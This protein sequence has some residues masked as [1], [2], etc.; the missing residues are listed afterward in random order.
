MSIALMES[1]RK[2]ERDARGMGMSVALHATV[3]G[4]AWYATAGA[5]AAAVRPTAVVVI[6]TYRQPERPTTPSTARR[7]GGGPSQRVYDPHI[8]DKIPPVVPGP[9]L[10]E[11]PVVS[12]DSLLAG[13]NDMGPGRDA[14]PATG[15]TPDGDGVFRT[16]D[17]MA[18][19]DPRNPAPDY[20]SMLRNAGVEGTV[21]AQFVVDTTGRVAASSIAFAQ[22]G[23]ALFQ[24]SV[25]RA[26]EAARFRPA[27][28]NGRAVRVLMA[29]A[30]QFRLAR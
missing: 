2:P 26:L 16:V 8:P 18:E 7:G 29:Q 17:V 27:L 28:V 21:S 24:R 23:N 6:P 10:L 4:L 15:A 30:F 14:G 22:G 20:P 3:I 12:W 19:P 9:V 13:P 1:A 11:E 25:R 5:T